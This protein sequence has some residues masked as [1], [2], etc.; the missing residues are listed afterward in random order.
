M[1]GLKVT[2]IRDDAA[3]G[4]SDSLFDD[5]RRFRFTPDRGGFL[6]TRSIRLGEIRVAEVSSAGH[7]IVLGAVGGAT[8]IAPESGRIGVRTPH[9]GFDAGAG[10]ALV[11]R[12]GARETFVRADSKRAFRALVAIAPYA[13]DQ[14][15]SRPA[16]AAIAGASARS[17]SGFLRYVFEEVERP[18]ASLL[19]PAS[20]AAAEAL[21]RDGFA[22]LDAF[23]APVAPTEVPGAAERRIRAA[24]DYILAHADGPLSVEDIARAVGVGPRALHAAFR[25]RLDTTPRA[26]LVE[27]RLERARARLRVP[28]P[29]T[30]VTDAALESGFVHLGRFATAYR[31]RFGESPSETLRRARDEG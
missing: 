11:L 8:F 13:A 31:Q 1:T 15:P 18:G 30:T 21:L 24:Q 12:P 6:R 28:G 16:G 9:A 26:L 25:D 7:D 3:Y 27:V 4:P 2:E 17:V 22:A 23:D 29:E 10:A 19:R 5:V 14:S 20:L